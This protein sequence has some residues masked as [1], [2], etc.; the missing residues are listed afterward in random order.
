MLSFVGLEPGYFQSGTIEFKRKMVKRGA[1]QLRYT[2]MNCTMPLI[3]YNMV[4]DE[5]YHKKRNKRKPRRVVLSHVAKKLICVI[6]TLETQ[7]TAF[8]ASKLR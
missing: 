5:Y 6:Y 4:F 3:M 8:E 1:S 2:L 7:N